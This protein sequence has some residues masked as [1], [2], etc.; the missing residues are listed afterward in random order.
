MSADPELVEGCPPKLPMV[1]QAHYDWFGKD[2]AIVLGAYKVNIDSHAG[3][4]KNGWEEP[5]FSHS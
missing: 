1:R 2:F 4:V 3:S 5:I